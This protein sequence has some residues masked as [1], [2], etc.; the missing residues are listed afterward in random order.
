[1]KLDFRKFILGGAFE[2]KMS[3]KVKKSIIFMP[4]SPRIIWTCFEFG[5]YWKSNNN[6]NNNNNVYLGT[7][8]NT[9]Y[10]N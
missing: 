1:M 3:Q 10:N 9:K 8:Q 4:P 5:K 7:I 2:K 6:D